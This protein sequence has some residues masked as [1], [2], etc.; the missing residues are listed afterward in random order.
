MEYLMHRS[1][2]TLNVPAWTFWSGMDLSE[3]QP[4]KAGRLRYPLQSNRIFTGLGAL[5]ALDNSSSS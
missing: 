5:A 1:K 3:S 4:Y 2:T